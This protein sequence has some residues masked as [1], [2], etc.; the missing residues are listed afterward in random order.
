MIMPM[1][2]TIIPNTDLKV[3]V[4]CLGSA[5]FGSEIASDESFRIMDKYAETGG[6]F[7]D[8]ARVY[9][10]WLP[11]GHGASETTIGNWLAQR[12]SRNKFILA[13]KGAH[14]DLKIM[15]ISRMSRK[16]IATDIEE[17]LRCLRTSHIDLYWLHRDD[18][19]IPVAD[20]LGIMEAF[21]EAGKIRYYGCSN[22]QA[23]RISEA[24][25]F[26]KSKKITGF[27]GN[28]PFWSLAQINPGTI[29]DKTLVQMSP[30]LFELHKNT[31]LAAIPYS[32]QAGGFFSK[33]ARG[34]DSLT[35]GMKKKFLNEPNE[36][37]MKRVAS[38]ADELNEPVATIP[39]AWLISQPFTTIPIIGPRDTSQLKE[40]LRAGDLIFSPN[41]IEVLRNPGQ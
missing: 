32:S 6:N 23:P 15:H 41:L 26:A 20:I 3:S 27:V 30:G 36:R 12:G 25:S 38:L 40:S 33:L 5:T 31:N 21:V 29:G 24:L 14:P 37:R 17:S 8:S 19:A 28:Q 4:I 9:A 11:N 22:W 16:D 35:S 39:L 2:Y 7:I 1:R 34:E 18:P 10:D 13:T